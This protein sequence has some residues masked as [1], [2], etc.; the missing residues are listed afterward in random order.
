[1]VQISENI[2]AGLDFKGAKISGIRFP[3]GAGRCGMSTADI[4]F[5]KISRLPVPRGAGVLDFSVSHFRK[6]NS[7]PIREEISVECA[8]G[9]TQ[10]KHG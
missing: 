5:S 2:G 9:E 10:K 6:H 7:G 3:S 4:R 1:M 8:Q